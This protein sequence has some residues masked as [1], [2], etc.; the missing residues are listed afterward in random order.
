MTR[1][2]EMDQRSSHKQIHELFGTGRGL[3]KRD[4]H[5]R[6][7]CNEGG[8]TGH[9]KGKRTELMRIHRLNNRSSKYGKTIWR[10]K[11]HTDSLLV[12]SR[13]QRS[14]LNSIQKAILHHISAWSSKDHHRKVQLMWV[15]MK[16]SKQAFQCIDFR[17]FPHEFSD[18]PDCFPSTLKTQVYLLQI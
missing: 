8:I 5:K 15:K 12:L 4:K 11:L 1:E 9:F 13:R 3:N 17:R 18:N 6:K 2:Q 14:R 7:Y 16:Q 10:L